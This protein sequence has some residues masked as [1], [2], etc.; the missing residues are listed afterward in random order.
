M[1]IADKAKNYPKKDQIITGLI[2]GLNT[3]QDETLIKDGELTEAKN[4]ILQVDGIEPRPGT[5][6]YL[7]D[8][9]EASVVGGIGFYQSDGTREF[10]TVS[11][12]TP[13]KYVGSTPTT[14]AG[15]TLTDATNINFVQA[16]DKVYGFN[17][18]D[19]HWYYDGSS[20]TQYTELSATASVT[21]T[22]T[23]A[24]G[25]TDYAYKIV[26]FN[27]VGETTATQGTTSTGNA[28][29]DATNYNAIS[30]TAVSGADGYMV[31]GRTS[32]GNGEEYMA[33]VYTNSYDDKGGDDPQ[34]GIEPP[35]Q[36]TTGGL[37]CDQ[38]IFAISRI[39]AAGDSTHPSRL[40]YSGVGTNLGN[41][42]TNEDVGGGWVDV[43]RN[44]GYKITGIAP[45]QGGVIVF[46]EN[47]VYK[48]TFTTIA[49]ADEYVSVGQL[50]EI[51]RS[52]GGISFRGIQAV[53]NDLVFPAKKNGRLAF[54]SLGNQEGYVGSVIRTNELSIKIQEKLE[55]VKLSRLEEAAGFYF[56]NIY[57]CAV[58]KANSS[59]NDRIWCLDTRFGSWVYWEGPDPNFFMT[60]VDTDGTEELYYGQ[61]TDGFM[62]E[63]FQDDRN[64][65]DSAISVEFTT[66]SFNQKVFHKY[67]KYYDP[68]YQF[69]GVSQSGQ[70]EGEIY[71]DGNILSADFT[72]NQQIG[73]GAGMGASLWGFTLPGEA[74]AGVGPTTGVSDD[75]VVEVDTI[76]RGRS[77]QYLFR[78][79]AA[80]LYYKLLSITHGYQVLPSKRLKQTQRYYPS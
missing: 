11:G 52:F 33:T 10:I 63:M 72:V 22:P 73:G 57:G 74:D 14:I 44:D 7:D 6:N 28:T 26:A 29:L 80:D 71:L 3:F 79:A 42:G 17:G 40:Y 46:K 30:W 9:G 12:T 25:S 19:F 49:L 2:G 27:E 70:L 37:K 15:L 35:E 54:Y 67:K 75:I 21:V 41:F 23:G 32:D 53:E 51:T 62:V 34:A 59:T 55:D 16:R 18:T 56:R 20:I 39:F 78:S 60:Y 5:V 4:I 69:K 66:K 13:K 68:T 50:E 31:Y 48:F 45:F 76:Q 8:S 64:D 43:F 58:T 47:A 1:R 38:A 61:E 77:I 36:N 65:N 24:S